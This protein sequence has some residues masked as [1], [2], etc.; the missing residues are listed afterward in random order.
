MVL[1]E[2]MS[3]Y[4]SKMALHDYELSGKKASLQAVGA[5]YV[6]LKICEQLKKTTLITNE[7]VNKLVSISRAKEEDIIEVS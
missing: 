3:L 2:K 1:I 4:L 5:L 6:S 7:I